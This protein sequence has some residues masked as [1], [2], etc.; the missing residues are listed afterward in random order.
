[1]IHSNTLFFVFACSF[2]SI[3]KMIA[4]DS[5][6]VQEKSWSTH[7]QMTAVT[8]WHSKFNSPYEGQNSLVSDEG[9]ATSLTSTLFLAWHPF[10]NFQIA[11]NPEMAGGKGLSSALGLGGFTNGECFRIGD[12]TP[13]VYLAR[14]VAEYY[15]PLGHATYELSADDVNQTA[16][17]VPKNYIKLFGGQFS[18]MDYFTKNPYSQDPRSQFMNWA[19]MAAGGWDY[20]ANTRGYIK[21]FGAQVKQGANTITVAATQLPKIHNGMELDEKVSQSFAIQGSYRRE[22]SLGNKKGAIEAVLFFNKT[23]MGNYE[24][25]IAK[26]PLAPNTDSVQNYNN[27]KYG[28]AINSFLDLGHDL[29][30]FMKLSWNDGHNET[31]AFTE[32]DHSILVGSQKKFSILK[33]PAQLGIACMVNGLS[34]G[35]KNYLANGGYGFMLGEGQLNYGMEGILELYSKIV[36][37]EGKLQLSPNYQLL[38][39]PGY[40]QDRGPV[41]V[42]GLRTHIEF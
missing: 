14:L 36:L 27:T 33:Y 17:M 5:S 3:T 37:M 16:M 30:V 7:F 26:N 41:H 42:F 22:V 40:N 8:Q 6:A 35:H 1:M 23:H 18:L 10:K 20:A 29:G 24:E 32:I 38:V 13:T 25:A 31:W 34:S 12:P 2:M 39:N 15:I 28:F 21:G 9:A 11:F 4:Q 19:A